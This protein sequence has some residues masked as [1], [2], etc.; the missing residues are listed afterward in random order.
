MLIP[1]SQNAVITIFAIVLLLAF[2]CTFI[3]CIVYFYQKKQ[4]SYFEKIEDLKES[5]Q[6]ALLQSQLEIQTQTFQNTSRE[7]HSNIGQKLILSKELLSTI[8]EVDLPE[9]RLRISTSVQQISEAMT[10]LRDIGRSM[11]SEVILNNGLIGGIEYELEKLNKLNTYSVDLVVIGEPVF[12]SV[13]KEL[14]LFRIIQEG[15]NNIRKHAEACEI[16]VQLEYSLN[17]LKLLIKD[18]GKGFNQVNNGQGTGLINIH[19]RAKLL[20]GSLVL[21]NDKGANLLIEIPT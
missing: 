5:H 15:I 8:V 10:D 17:S 12:L 2:L 11:S 19:K 20:Q 6:S 7:I 4:L 13:N 18:N 14:V 21:Q 16:I 1:S 3:V 9:A